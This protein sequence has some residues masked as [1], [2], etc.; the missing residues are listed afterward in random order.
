M[1]PRFVSTEEINTIGKLSSSLPTGHIHHQHKVTMYSHLITQLIRLLTTG[2]DGTKAS[3]IQPHDFI[4]IRSFRLGMLHF[5]AC[6]EYRS[7]TRFRGKFPM[8]I[9]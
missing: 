1:Q 4:G 3:N 5:P 8:K 7:G 9:M 6:E 2:D